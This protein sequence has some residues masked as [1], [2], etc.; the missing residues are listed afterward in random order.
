[1]NVA[2]PAP[3]HSAMFGQRA[4]SHTVWSALLFTSPFSHAYWPAPGIRTFSQSGRRSGGAGLRM[5]SSI[6]RLERRGFRV[7]SFQQFDEARHELAAH[8]AINQA[9][10]MRE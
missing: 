10:I 3:Q 4:S 7:E 9:M 2:V 1:M 8:H 6:V 5:G